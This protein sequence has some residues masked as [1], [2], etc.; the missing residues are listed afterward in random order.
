MFTWCLCKIFTCVQE[1]I[2]LGDSN[3]NHGW[4]PF[5]VTQYQMWVDTYWTFVRDNR[6]F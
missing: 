5:I 4:V 6:D 1:G 2:F 3:K